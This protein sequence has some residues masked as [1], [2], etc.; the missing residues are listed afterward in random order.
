[1]KWREDTEEPVAVFLVTDY[2]RISWKASEGED[3]AGAQQWG[4]VVQS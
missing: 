1:M 4:G 2:P 3:I